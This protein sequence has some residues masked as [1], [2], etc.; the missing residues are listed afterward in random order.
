MLLEQLPVWLLLLVFGAIVVHAPVTVW[1][2]ATYP[3][4]GVPSKAWKE[5]LM[6]VALLLLTVALWRAGQLKAFIKRPLVVIALLYIGLHILLMGVYPQPVAAM[7]A[8]LMIDLRYVAFFLAVYA[9]LTLYPHYRA[10]FVR[11]GVAG[12]IIVV[13]FAT[14]QLFLP[15]DFL[16]H[17]G[18]SSATI[19]P[20]MTVDKNPDFIRCSSTLRGPNPLGAYGGIVVSGAVAYLLAM[21]RRGAAKGWQL[22]MARALLVLGA[23]AVWLSYSRS[24]LI[25]AL[26]AVLIVVLVARGKWPI[27]GRAKLV[28]AG[29]V[30]VMA[31]S[32]F[33]AKDTTEF[34]NIILH[35]NP[36]TGAAID[37]N[38]AHA[39]SFMDGLNRL[40][41]Q[42]LGAGVGST[43]S[44]SLFGGE[45]LIIENQ[46][47]MIAHEAG[48]GGLLL[49]LGLFGL[50]LYELWQRRTNWLALTVLASGL[51]LAAIGMLLPVWADDTVSIV[52]WGLAAIALIGGQNGQGTTNQKAKRTT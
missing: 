32:L 21:R 11:A 50:L 26:L 8:G 29:A 39:E 30:L 40:A 24:A 49:F 46:Y 16:K 13:G 51:G 4:F 28:L 20:Y 17:I 9:A 7:V 31:T 47:L 27:S 45:G 1:I 34:K 2:S 37:S 23:V 44:A 6:A 33:V 5:G 12:A 18:Y 35:D 19:E 10:W 22:W 36:A 25:G 15:V 42:P 43:G 41:V 3:D 38:S 48:W 52:W 14:L